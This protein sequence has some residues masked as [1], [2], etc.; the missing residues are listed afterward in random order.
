MHAKKFLLSPLHIKKK[1][2]NKL[3]FESLSFQSQN[4][5]KLFLL[6]LTFLFLMYYGSVENTHRKTSLPWDEGDTFLISVDTPHVI[7]Y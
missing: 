7:Y 4:F 1:S 5:D 3:N 2:E 6:K